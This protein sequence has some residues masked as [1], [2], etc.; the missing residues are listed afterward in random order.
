MRA[1]GSVAETQLLHSGETPAIVGPVFVLRISRQLP[2][3]LLTPRE[4]GSFEP[5]PGLWYGNKSIRA[6]FGGPGQLHGGELRSPPAPSSSGPTSPG[7]P[8]PGGVAV[9]T[10]ALFSTV[11]P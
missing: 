5:A 1:L 6:A 9:G 3:K 8:L 4:R 7:T 11:F 10:D 2:A